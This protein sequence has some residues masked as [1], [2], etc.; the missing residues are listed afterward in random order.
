MYIHF[1]FVAFF[2]VGF[3]EFFSKFQIP[4]VT[5]LLVWAPTGNKLVSYKQ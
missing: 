1:F 4:P 2:S 5:Q 3:R